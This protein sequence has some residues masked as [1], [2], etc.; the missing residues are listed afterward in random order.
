M[1]LEST[2]FQGFGTQNTKSDTPG[3]QC[4]ASLIATLT[5]GQRIVGP[6]LVAS[7]ARKSEEI[8]ISATFKLLIK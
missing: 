6:Q 5:F 1:P 7:H 2:K 4:S 8:K 3:T